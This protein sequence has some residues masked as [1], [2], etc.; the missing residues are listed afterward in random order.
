MSTE[1]ESLLILLDDPDEEVYQ[2]IRAKILELGPRILSRLEA[3]AALASTLPVHQRYL[4]L[5]GH[6]QTDY[7]CQELR[8]WKS[9]DVPRLMEGGWLLTRFLFSDLTFSD[10]QGTIQPYVREIWMELNNKLTALERIRV[11]NHF[12]FEKQRFRMNEDYPESIGNNFLNRLIE[13]KRGNEYSLTLFYA[14]VAQEL[15][16]P[17]FPVLFPGL[18]LLAHLDL[19]VNPEAH[20][21]PSEAKILFYVNPSQSGIV[22]GRHDLLDYLH[23]QEEP[24]SKTTLRATKLDHLIYKCFQRLADDLASAGSLNRLRQ[25]ERILALWDFFSP[26]ID[27]DE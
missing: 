13:N 11:M 27:L 8:K 9:E 2:S 19:V 4:E 5:I 24:F 6:L 15:D 22:H 3:G 10:L 12:L 17:L 21:A 20:L 18:P 16:I 1:E 25:A 7:I 23:Q 14:I 26:K